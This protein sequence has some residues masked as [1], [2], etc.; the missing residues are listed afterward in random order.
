MRRQEERNHEAVL[1]SIGTKSGVVR[2]SN[3]A[4]FSRL[5]LVNG[6]DKR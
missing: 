1:L 3:N 2:S 4:M 5:K 6:C